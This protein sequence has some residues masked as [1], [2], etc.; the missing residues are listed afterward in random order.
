MLTVAR[1]QL[2]KGRYCYKIANYLR[3]LRMRIQSMSG[4][5]SGGL[6]FRLWRLVRILRH[7]ITDCTLEAA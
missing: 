4:R 1:P 6:P 7:Q 2:D 5:R 3:L